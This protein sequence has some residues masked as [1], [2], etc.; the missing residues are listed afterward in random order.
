MIAEYKICKRCVLDTT[1]KEITFDENGICNHCKSFE[2][3]L[4]ERI[5]YGEKRKRHLD[6]IVK[7]IKKSGKGKKYNCIIGVS[8]GIDSTYVAYMVKKE[9]GLKR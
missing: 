4:K 3:K 8:G 6:K 7:K 2:E 9:L 5:L 1:D